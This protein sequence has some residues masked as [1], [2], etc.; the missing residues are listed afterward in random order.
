MIDDAPLHLTLVTLNIVKQGFSISVA[1]V[2]LFSHL[3][4]QLD[5]YLWATLGV[6]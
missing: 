3:V 2:N 6:S 5:I 1:E 4:A